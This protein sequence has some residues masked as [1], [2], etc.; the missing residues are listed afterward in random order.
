VKLL[1]LFE[2]EMARPDK[3]PF[4]A[5]IMEVKAHGFM[6]ELT[7]SQAYGLVHMTTL[8]DDFYRMHP[9]GNALVGRRNGRVYAVGASL[10]VTVDKVDRFKRQVDFRVFEEAYTPTRGPE[11]R[12]GG[13]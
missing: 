5:R 2:R 1:E 8:S 12:K 9:D 3:R 13:R 4:E 6:V 7:A 10:Q 11:R